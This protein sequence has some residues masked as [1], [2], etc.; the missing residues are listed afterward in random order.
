MALSKKAKPKKPWKEVANAAQEHRD[1]TLATFA[2]NV[3]AALASNSNPTNI[4]E[5]V[6]QAEYLAITALLPEELVKHLANGELTAT[7][8]TTAF[9]RRAAL[10]QALVDSRT[11]KGLKQCMN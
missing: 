6:L 7:E 5:R 11:I 2:T 8:V 4:P 10:A 9:L 1:A 3:P